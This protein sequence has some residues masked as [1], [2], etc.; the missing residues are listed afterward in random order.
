MARTVD[1]IFQSLLAEKSTFASLDGLN[2]SGIN[3]VQEL[4]TK[5]NSDSIVSEHIL[6]MY[7]FANES[8]LTEQ[9]FD[10][11]RAEI[12][13][14]T[15]EAFVGTPEWLIKTA[16]EF[17]YGDLLVVDPITF[18]IGYDVIDE[19]KQVIGSVAIAENSNLVIMK[20]R[21]K[22]SD[23]LSSDELTAFNGYIN[24]VKIAGQ[25]IVIWNYSPDTLKLYM[26]V[27]YSK[28]F[29]LSTIRTNVENAINNYIKNIEF[30]SYFNVNSMV[31]K[32]QAVSGII[33]PR[34]D[35]GEGRFGANSYVPFTHEYLATAGYCSIDGSF[36]L[37]TTITYIPK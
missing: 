22:N 32:I 30:N 37:S 14:I 35:S 2:D 29:P 23:L 20:V 17:Q 26:T 25:N 9:V 16:K 27:V 34:F 19:S 10:E 28:Q 21:G 33:D 13:A 12:Q 7:L 5:A 36:P 4:I 6:W 31:D 8:S 11:H 1:T 18:A 3:N 15:D 24:K